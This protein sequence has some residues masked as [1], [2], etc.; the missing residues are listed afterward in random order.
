MDQYSRT[1]IM[2]GPA[3]MERLRQ[4]RVAVF[5]LGGVGGS[6]VEAL[7]RGGVGKLVLVDH[8]TVSL[9]NLNRQLLAT[10]ETVGLPKTEAA[11]RR[12]LAIDPTIQ[13]T[14]REVFYGPDTADTFDFSDFDYVVDAIDTVTGKLQLI[15]AA[16]KAGVPIVCCMG[17]GNKWDPTRFQIADLSQTSVCPLARIMRKECA[18]R[19]FQNIKV[20]YSTEEPAENIWQPEEA[21][22]EGRRSIPGSLSFVPPVAGMIL[23]GQVIRDLIGKITN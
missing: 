21:P 10:H 16:R 20:L 17:T 5:G 13:V 1:Q 9:T 12:V 4:A 11:R 2:V 6:A 23:A 8:D 18:K 19:G 14:V 22:P 15:E 3:A 7:A